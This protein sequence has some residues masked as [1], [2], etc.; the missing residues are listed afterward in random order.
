MLKLD[1]FMLMSKPYRY[2]GHY[3]TTYDQVN[4]HAFGFWFFSFGWHFAVK[5]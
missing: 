3:K 4:Y 5:D 1:G 2:V